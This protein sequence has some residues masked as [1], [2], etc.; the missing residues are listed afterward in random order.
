MPHDLLIRDD[1]DIDQG[2]RFRIK[3]CGQ[4]GVIKLIQLAHRVRI[5]R[6]LTVIEQQWNHQRQLLV[7]RIKM[8]L[9]RRD[10]VSHQA[11]GHIFL[12]G[13]FWCSIRQ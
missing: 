13:E 9:H 3:L 2:K 11:K 12:S 1:S 4:F 5:R 10:T 6:L 7:T 8:E